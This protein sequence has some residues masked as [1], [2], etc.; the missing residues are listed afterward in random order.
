[1]RVLVSGSTGF[2]GM[3]LVSYLKGHG[4][5]VTR[6]ARSAGDS[7]DSE[8]IW[9]PGRGAIDRIQ[10]E[11]FDAVVHLS[12]E[13]LSVSRWSAAK[14]AR[15][16]DSR[17]NST[18]FLCE[19]LAS[20]EHPPAALLCA[21][22]IGYYGSRGDE[23]L[24][25]ESSPGEGFLAEVCQAWE[26]A[27]APAVESSIRVAHLRFGLVLSPRG[28]ALKAMLTP[29]KLG[30]GGV[31]GDG[32]QYVGWIALDDAVG[33]VHHILMHDALAGPIN[34]VAP[35]PVTNREFVKALGRTLRRPTLVALPSAVVRMLLGEAAEALLL[36]G[37]RVQCAKLSASGYVHKH[38]KIE[39]ALHYMLGVEG[40]AEASSRM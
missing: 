14:R 17:V 22:A 11:G 24:T 12:G 3:S 32:R 34:V 7:G 20:L 31:F 9:D 30:L 40:A 21:S 29:F 23:M 13:R 4:A 39:P 33:A 1:M 10:L 37:T 5:H 6:L 16:R 35:N 15:I 2:I 27:A 25:E 18:A 28:G 19:A 38:P 26:A 8:T 36:A